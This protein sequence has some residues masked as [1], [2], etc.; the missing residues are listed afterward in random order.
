MKVSK[1]FTLYELTASN[2]AKR[3]GINNTPSVEEKSNLVVL[4]ELLDEVREFINKPL[5]LTSAYRSPLLNRRVG[6]TENSVHTMGLAADISICEADQKQVMKWFREK[7]DYWKTTRYCPDQ[8]IAYP[9]RGFIHIGLSSKNSPRLQ[10]LCSK[11]KGQ[12]ET[13]VF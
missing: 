13:Y 3:Y 9:K 5:F 11:T 1:Y 10:F 8:I 7:S 6:G 12:Y 4:S 2:T